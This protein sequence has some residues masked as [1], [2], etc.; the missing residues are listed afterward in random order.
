MDKKLPKLLKIA[1]KSKKDEGYNQ[2]EG[3]TWHI[4]DKVFNMV[5]EAEL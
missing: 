1:E 2:A 5:I 3:Y 4:R